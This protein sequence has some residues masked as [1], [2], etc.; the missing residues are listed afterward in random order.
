MGEFLTNK[1]LFAFIEVLIGA[2]GFSKVELLALVEKI[3]WFTTSNDRPKLSE[4]IRKELYLYPEVKHGCESV[5]SVL[6]GS[7]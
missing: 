1:E 2:R 7:S 6:R 4:L 3:K 5:Q